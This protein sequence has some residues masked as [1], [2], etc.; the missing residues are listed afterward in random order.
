MNILNNRSE[1]VEILPGIFLRAVTSDKF[2]TG[3][4]SIN[5]LRPL[6][7]VEASKNVLIPSIL[8]RGCAQYPDIAAISNRLDELYGATIGSLTRKKGEVQCVGLYS[9]FIE[10][11]FV[12]EPVFAP[13]VE[14]VGQLLLS[15]NLQGGRFP[16]DVLNSERQNLVSAIASRINDKRSHAINQMLEAMCPNEAYHIP[17]LGY[18]EPLAQLTAQSIYDHYRRVLATSRVEIFYMGRQDV[19]T[20]AD[21]FRRALSGLERQAQIPVGTR[22]VSKA[23]EPQ[24]CQQAMRVTQGQLILGLRTGCTASDADYPAL[25]LLNAV[26]GQGQ[27]SK[28]FENVREKRSLCYSISSSVEK[29]KGIM[30]IHAGVGF[31]HFDTARDAILK[32]LDDCKNGAITPQELQDARQSLLSAFAANQD[33]PGALDDFYLGMS[34]ADRVQDT[35]YLARAVRELG[36]ED[37][38]AA[39][40]KISLDTVFYLT[41]VD[42]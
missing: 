3:C 41:G 10:D 42:A 11:R 9:D 23:A 8:L 25:L 12:S 31:D 37:V 30:I 39:A 18:A 36:I 21:T 38:A 5:F 4:F 20:A 16:P 2:K 29:F 34:L 28:L 17:R 35:E 26:L 32:E 22:V 13:V 40:Q 24:Y 33:S 14:L 27:S 15:P 1:R 19:Q 6:D 7:A